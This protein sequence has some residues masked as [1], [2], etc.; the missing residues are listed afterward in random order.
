MLANTTVAPVNGAITQHEAQEERIGKHAVH[1]LASLFPLLIGE[2]YE[3]LVA[4]IKVS[5]QNLPIVLDQNGSVVDGR[6]RY[7]ALL[8]LGIEPK[9]ETRVFENDTQ[10]SQYLF[11][12][13]IARRHL[14]TPE[15]AFLAAALQKT[16]RPQ[17]LENKNRGVPPNL[18]GGPPVGDTRDVAGALVGGVSHTNVDIARRANEVD[19][20]IGAL[21]KTGKVKSMA[22]VERLAKLDPEQRSAAIEKLEK[23]PAKNTI[24]KP[25]GTSPK[26]PPNSDSP[27]APKESKEDKRIDTM[28]FTA[29]KLCDELEVHFPE[30]NKGEFIRKYLSEVHGFNRAKVDKAI[31]FFTVLRQIGD[32]LK[33]FAPVA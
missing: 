17:A 6:N 18:A 8:D 7:R 25:K 31:D 22:E 11:N 10:L 15:R 14:T 3:R 13:N 30:P 20:R 2:E 32:D 9:F 16:L 12:A 29:M 19:P 23:A 24:K 33:W 26:T 4:G 5:G 1:R 21:V 28:F 27:T